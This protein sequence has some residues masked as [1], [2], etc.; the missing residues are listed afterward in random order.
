MDSNVLF[1]WIPFYTVT[2]LVKIHCNH[3]SAPPPGGV[4]MK[5]YLNSDLFFVTVSLLDAIF[6]FFK[7]LNLNVGCRVLVCLFFLFSLSFLMFFKIII[8]NHTHDNIKNQLLVT[9]LWQCAGV[10]KKGQIIQ[11]FVTEYYYTYLSV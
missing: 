8:N 6:F 7:S 1:A 5:C 9:W 11:C 2:P 3:S 4:M 10:I